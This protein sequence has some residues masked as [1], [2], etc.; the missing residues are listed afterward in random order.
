M[1]KLGLRLPQRTGDLRRDVAEVARTLPA[2]GSARAPWSRQRTPRSSWPRASRRSDQ[3]RTNDCRQSRRAGRAMSWSS[4]PTRS[5][6]SRLLRS[7]SCSPATPPATGHRFGN[8]TFADRPPRDD[9]V[10]FTGTVDHVIDDIGAAAA[11]VI[12]DL[13]RY[14]H[15]LRDRRRDRPHRRPRAR[16]A[17]AAVAAQIDDCCPGPGGSDVVDDV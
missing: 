8:V 11:E 3:R 4:H 14:A 10:P 9:R 1:I 7:R 17:P 13:S 15:D 12:I 16:P 2:R 5:V 6:P